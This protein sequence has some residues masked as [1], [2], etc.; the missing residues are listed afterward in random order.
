MSDWAVMSGIGL[1]F[2]A[3]YLLLGRSCNQLLIPERYKPSVHPKLM[4]RNLVAIVPY[5]LACGFMV[6]GFRSL[7]NT[8]QI[9]HLARFWGWEENAREARRWAQE[10]RVFEDGESMAQPASWE[11]NDW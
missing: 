5:F 11:D 10:G 1:G 6:A 4:P 3:A 9:N 7:C 2:P 8:T